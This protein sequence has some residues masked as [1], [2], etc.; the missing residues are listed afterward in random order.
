M[1]T[2][3]ETDKAQKFSAWVDKRMDE[4]LSEWRTC[5]VKAMYLE[6]LIHE[7]IWEDDGGRCV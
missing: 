4:F 6:M 7:S 5:L 1:P 3:A 2:I